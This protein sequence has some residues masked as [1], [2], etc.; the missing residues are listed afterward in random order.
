MPK[1]RLKEVSLI[2]TVLNEADNI[3]EFMDSIL[4]QTVLP[5]EFI[6]VDGGS[7]DGTYEILEE[8]AKKYKWIKIYQAKG[9]SIGK[10]RNIAIEK[11]KGKI[12]AVTDAGCI[13]DK[14][15]LENLYKTFRKYNGKYEVISGIYECIGKSTIQKAM[16]IVVCPDNKTLPDDV[17]PSSR[18]TLFT[19]KAW[20]KASGYP[21]TSTADDAIFNIK[22]KLNGVKFKIARD[23][24]VYWIM[25]KDIKSFS[26]QFFR[27]G[28]GDG[29]FR[30]PFMYF[31]LPRNK[32]IRGSF[33]AMI[34]GFSSIFFT[35]L[36][37]VYNKLFLIP[38]FMLF[39]TDFA[40]KLRWKNTK[41]SATILLLSFILLILK[42]FSYFTG[43]MYGF[44]HKGEK[45]PSLS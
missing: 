24:K 35:F 27:Y 25:K 8:Y 44:F 45:F 2:T 33:F 26:R 34:Y 20:K 5:R 42:R 23:A 19:K 3:K 31:K 39:I 18:S 22:L 43:L 15:W 36:S 16:S 30:I 28:F 11:A 40:K 21:N 13:V 37:V 29:I 12:I 14:K 17:E 10:G 7:T 1:K 6:I 38:L 4:N 32:D 9:A 41:V